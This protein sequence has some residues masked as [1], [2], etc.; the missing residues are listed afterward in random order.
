MSIEELYVKHVYNSIAKEFS[1]TRYRPWTCVENFL[2]GV[3][4]RFI[5]QI[6]VAEMEKYALSESCYNFGCDFSKETC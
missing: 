3:K 1:D 6:L 4:P 5:L 2:D